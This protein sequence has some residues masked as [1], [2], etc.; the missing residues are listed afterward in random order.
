MDPRWLHLRLYYVASRFDDGIG[1]RNAFHSIIS[2]LSAGRRD[3]PVATVVPVDG[4]RLLED[5]TGCSSVEIGN[6]TTFIAI[7][8]L[9]LDPVQAETELWIHHGR[10]E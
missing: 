2:A 3:L 6:M 8:A 4:I 9:A 1:V 5:G 10:E 7:Q